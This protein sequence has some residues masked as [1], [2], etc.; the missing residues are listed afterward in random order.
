MR[1]MARKDGLGFI[2]LLARTASLV[3]NFHMAHIITLG[4]KGGV[5]R[6]LLLGSNCGLAHNG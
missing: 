1:K 6:N 5:A 3:F 4:S 2:K